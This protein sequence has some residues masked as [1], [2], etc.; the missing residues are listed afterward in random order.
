MNE[1]N[2]KKNKNYYFP[3]FIG[4]GVI[5]GIIFDKL[6]IGLCLGVAIGLALENKKKK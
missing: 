5:F 2:D 6:A 3:L 4:I 1:N